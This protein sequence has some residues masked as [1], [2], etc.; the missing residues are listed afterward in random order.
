MYDGPIIDIHAH[1]RLGDADKVDD[2]HGKGVKPL[3]E[4]VRVDNVRHATAIV[5]ALRDDPATSE[6]NDGALAAA[7][8]LGF[9]DDEERQML[10]GNAAGLLNLDRR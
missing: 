2:S 10:Y 7:R 4:A 5:I 9:T 8:S 3:V 6:K 1:I